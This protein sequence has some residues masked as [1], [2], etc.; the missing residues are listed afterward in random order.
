MS[1]YVETVELFPKLN[2]KLAELLKTLSPEDFHKSTQFP[3]W[4]VKDICA[5][6][7]DTSLRRLSLERDRY[8][9]SEKAEIE[10]DADLIRHVMRLARY[11]QSLWIGNLNDFS[12]RQPLHQPALHSRT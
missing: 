6:L 2:D 5:H 10:S 4:K 7:L 12:V 3:S 1:D 8:A 9:S 11:C